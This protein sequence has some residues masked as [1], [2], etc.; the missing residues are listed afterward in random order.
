RGPGDP[1]RIM[2][3]AR[4]PGL[5]RLD[6]GERIDELERHGWLAPGDA[7]LLRQGDHVLSATAAD[8]IIE[9]VIGSFGLPFAIAPNFTVNE[10]DYIVPLV[11]EEPSIV[12]ALS[13]AARLARDFGGFRATLEESLLAGQVHVT[14]V[15]DVTAAMRVLDDAK[16][17]LVEEANRIHP[18]LV[19]RGG[20]VRD[21]E[22]R[23]IELPGGAAAIVVHVLVDTRDAMGA[24][25]VNTICERLAPRIGT[26]AG[27]NV[28]LRILSNFCDRSLATAVVRYEF[29]DVR[30]RDAIAL[31]SD[32]AEADPYRAATHNKGV[33]NG[34]DGLAIATGNDWRA[35][36]A[37]AHA[38]AA[39]TG[40]YRPLATW[41]ADGNA[42]LVGELTL[43]LKVGIVGGTLEANPGAALGLRLTGVASAAELAMLMA[44]VGLAQNFAALRALATDGIQRGHMRLHARS[45]A[46]AVATPQHLFDDVVAELVASGDVKDWKAREILE[47]RQAAAESQPRGKSAAGKVILLGEHAVVYGKHA[48]AVPLPDAVFATVTRGQAQAE[49]TIP[50][51]GLR[52]ALNAAAPDNGIDAIVSTIANALSVDVGDVAIEVRCALPRAMGLGSSAAIAV[53]VTRALAASFDI[54][55]DDQRVN[56][57]A[58]ACEQ[59]THGTPSGIDNTLATFAR[60]MLYRRGAALEPFELDEPPPLVVACSHTGGLTAEQVAGV[61]ER[62]EQQA[63]HYDAMFSIMDELALAGAEALRSADWAALGRQM[64]VCHGLLNAIQVSTPELER[65]V[66]LARGAGALGAKL[67]GAGGGGSIVALC[68]GTREQVSNALAAAGYRIF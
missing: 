45:V 67:T 30:E 41:R 47:Q 8:K 58:Y 54:D 2:K 62:R 63:A 56:D 38:Y 34:I 4:I 64:N 52:H 7:A 40:R 57:I 14:N 25:L 13:G 31:A 12:A 33:M 49:L 44:A 37:G 36:E 17:S 20:G 68:P 15:A 51:W 39:S 46:A 5:Y 66:T 42:G 55:V 18:R 16:A 1:A 59:V 11:V 53:A 21:L 50:E 43:P 28:A 60:P 65:M 29:D 10:R 32:L 24:N 22:L 19:E 48:L 23:T 35:I 6:V 3:D 61:R 26:L 9:N 27:G